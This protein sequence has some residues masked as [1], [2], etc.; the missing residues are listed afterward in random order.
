VAAAG[1][2]DNQEPAQSPLVIAKTPTKS[3]DQQ[4]GLPGTM[5]PSPL[6]VLVTRDGQPVAQTT[7]AWRAQNG[8]SFDAPS[9]PTDASGIATGNW[10][11]GP[12]VGPQT[13]T[14]TI[15]GAQ[16]S[17]L[18]FTATAADDGGGPPPPVIVSVEGPPTFQFSPATITITVGQTVTWT[19][20]EGALAHNV[21]PDDVANKI[22]PGE[23]GLFDAPHT[24]SYTFT[25]PGT[26]HYHCSNHGAAGGVGMSGTVVVGAAQ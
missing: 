4:T 9:T 1:C 2:N 15:A 5:L 12:N 22:P 8:G 18:T 21:T 24:Y 23:A 16:G 20:A 14:A 10:T 7:V 6:R 19:W 25:Q 11:L 3:G 13:A 26:Y 17:P